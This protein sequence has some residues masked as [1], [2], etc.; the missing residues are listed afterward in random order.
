MG[1]TKL[2]RASRDG[3][4]AGEATERPFG[5]R[6]AVQVQQKWRADQRKADD[7]NLGIIGCAGNTCVTCIH[8]SKWARYCMS[9]TSDR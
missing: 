6:A 9:W 3:S 7:V 5:K 8:V 1:R 2:W 4:G